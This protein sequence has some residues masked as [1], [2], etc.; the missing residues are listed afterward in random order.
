VERG[1][2]GLSTAHTFHTRGD[3][4]SALDG[5]LE[6]GGKSLKTRW[7]REVA[8]RRELIDLITRISKTA[9]DKGLPG[10]AQKGGIEN[11]RADIG[12]FRWRTRASMAP[13]AEEWTS[14]HRERVERLTEMLES[15]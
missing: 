15:S 5:T 8:E 4:E 9:G 10:K 13:T 12:K 2:P 14:T 7:G 6:E 3:A 11:F 1:T